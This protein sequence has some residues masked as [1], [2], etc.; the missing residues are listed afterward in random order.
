MF[1]KLMKFV[2][3]VVFLSLVVVLYLNCACKCKYCFTRMN[4]RFTYYDGRRPC[5]SLFR[6]CNE[7]G[8]FG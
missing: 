1:V 7:C 4:C 2:V 3:V 6:V 8:M 5:S